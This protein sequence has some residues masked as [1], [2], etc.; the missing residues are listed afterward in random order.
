MIVNFKRINY[1][2]ILGYI[3]NGSSYSLLLKYWQLV[4]FLAYW[5]KKILFTRNFKISYKKYQTQL[6][7]FRS[8]YRYFSRYYRS[9]KYYDYDD[10]L[11]NYLI[12]FN[13]KNYLNDELNYNLNELKVEKK[14]NTQLDLS[15]FLLDD[16]EMPI[17]YSYNYNLY[18]LQYL[19]KCY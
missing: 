10:N 9:I 13:I 2:K 1:L 19:N 15:V 5:Y 6:N 11:N 14:K 8:F 17:T 3:Y 16:I 7:L 4:Y 12:N 18:S